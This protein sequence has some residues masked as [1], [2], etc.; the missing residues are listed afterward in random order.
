MFRAPQHGLA[1]M[2]VALAAGATTARAAVSAP[3]GYI[4]SGLTLA[5]ST[6]NCV[7]SGP[8]GT[9]VGV[10]RA[11]TANGEAIVLVRES[12]DARLIALGFNS[13]GDCAYDAATD[14]LYV[15]DNA[16][17]GDLAITTGFAGN[18]GAQSGD[19]LFAIANASTVSAV[20][21]PDA[22]LLPA[23]SLEFPANIAV[24]AAGNLIVSSAD[25]SGA[26][27]LLE[28]TPGP[29]SSVL[30]AGFDF[31]GGVAIHPAS[32]D[33]IAAE[34]RA[35]FD[36]QLHRFTSAG[37]VVASPLLGPSFGFGSADLAFTLD[38]QLLVTGLFGGDV[39]AVDL[40]GPTATSFISGLTYA[41]GIAVNPFTGRVEVLSST[42]SGAAEDKTIHRFIPVARLL[43][44]GTDGAS[45]CLHEFYGV[46]LAP[47]EPGAEAK[48]AVCVDGAPCD[49]DGQVNNQ[50]LF[51]IG[52]CFNVADPRLPQCSASAALRTFAA[53]AKRDVR[54]VTRMQSDVLAAL[55][56]TGPSC[57][58][59]DGVVVPLK[60]TA[61]GAKKSG[62]DKVTV[63]VEDANGDKDSD[64]VTLVCRPAA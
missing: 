33:V 2:V 25:G 20:N 24:D 15:S 8:G 64:S 18:T 17:N 35:A 56:L 62:K 41:G 19:T 30:R 45:E 21:A 34:T 22:E 60:V 1:L 42:F 47:P 28:I 63:S 37:A 4:Y 7:A 5:S 23:N 40:T 52:S 53:K 49:A 16:D 11:F 13:I 58:F 36:A 9:F 31:T 54:G 44:G 26:G 10:G 6:Q 38:G 27:K 39:M 50:C 32:G 3:A 55:P 12:G 29:T 59:T 51:P 61:S 43:P 57:S 14:T 46:E 48:D